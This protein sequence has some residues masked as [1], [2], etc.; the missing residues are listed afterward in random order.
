V[1]GVGVG[2]TTVVDGV[3]LGVGVGVGNGQVP[4]LVI[5]NASPENLEGAIREQ[6]T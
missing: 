5:T 4:R 6:T 3:M 1:V 2:V